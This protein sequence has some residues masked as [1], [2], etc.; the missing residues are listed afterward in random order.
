MY[1]GVDDIRAEGITEETI[2][3]AALIKRIKAAC[4][5]I[6]LWTSLWFEPREKTIVLDGRGGRV[7]FLD[8]P[9]I[10]LISV[11]VDRENIPAVSVRVIDDGYSLFLE[12]G[13]R[14]GVRSVE[15][16]GTFG[17]VVADADSPNG[18]SPP[19][20]II[21]AVKRLTLREVVS[22]TDAEAQ[23]EMTRSGRLIS[24]TTDGH[25][26]TL[27]S[28]NTTTAAVGMFGNWTGDTYIDSILMNYQPPIRLGCA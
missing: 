28:T 19:S 22:L 2:G 8:I 9:V 12:R 20:P 24:E 15:I 17:V 21:E 26:Y 7:L 11:L 13:W 14:G 27:A 10:A 18:Y 4:D 25:S 16:T 23:N 1:C 6:D 5:K 3:D